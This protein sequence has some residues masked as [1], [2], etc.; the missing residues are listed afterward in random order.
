MA[1]EEGGANNL[2]ELL[3]VNNNYQQTSTFQA[4]EG[5]N[6]KK[7]SM[8]RGAGLIKNTTKLKSSI[9]GSLKPL[10]ATPTLSLGVTGNG[11]SNEDSD[12]FMQQHL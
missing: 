12:D 7:T 8:G 11:M 10:G 4:T 2:G 1:T 6:P 5:L 3:S 9:A